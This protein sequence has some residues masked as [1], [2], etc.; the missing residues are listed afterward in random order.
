V[1]CEHPPTQSPVLAARSSGTASPRA[2]LTVLPHSAASPARSSRRFAP[3]KLAS[4]ASWYLLFFADH[5]SMSADAHRVLP[6]PAPA[7]AG[8]SVLE[9]PLGAEEESRGI[10]VE[11]PGEPVVGGLRTWVAKAQLEAA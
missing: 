8:D 1:W 3:S 10:L 9:L 11:L 6:S 5:E 4:A 2:R 7:F